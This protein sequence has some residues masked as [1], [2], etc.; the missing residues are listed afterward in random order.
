MT[1]QKRGDAEFLLRD[2]SLT[3]F[4]PYLTTTPPR[5]FF[6]NSVLQEEQQFIFKILIFLPLS[7]QFHSPSY[8]LSSFHQLPALSCPISL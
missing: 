5:F 1:I 4:F 7:N 2:L 8:L 3:S 6:F